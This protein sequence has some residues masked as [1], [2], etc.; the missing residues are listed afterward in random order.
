[1]G[2]NK[3]IL[4]FVNSYQQ[5]HRRRLGWSGLNWTTFPLTPALLGVAVIAQLIPVQGP[6]NTAHVG[7]SHVETYE[8][9]ENSVK[10]SFGCPSHK[11][12]S[13][14]NQHIFHKLHLRNM[15]LVRLENSQKS[16]ACVVRGKGQKR[17][18]SVVWQLKFQH[19]CEGKGRAKLP[20]PLSFWAEKGEH[21]I[22]S[23]RQLACS[24]Y[25]PNLDAS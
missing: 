22:T 4:I 15:W 16:E 5:G 21:G 13:L 7:Q 10:Q 25:I 12:F 9:A 20:D 8:M 17:W 11:N 2:R 1:M 6:T 19:F 14:F 23:Q 3:S 18:N 24:D